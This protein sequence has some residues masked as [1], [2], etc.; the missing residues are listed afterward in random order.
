MS[1]SLVSAR[2]P[3]ALV[4]VSTFVLADCAAGTD[5]IAAG[6]VTLEPRIDRFLREPPEVR[7]D[8]GDLV[9]SG[10]LER[11]LPRDLGGHIDI[12]VIAPDGS[13]VFDAQTDY[14]SETVSSQGRPGPR[15]GYFRRAHTRYGSSGVYLVRFHGL[16]PDSSVVKVSHHLLPHSEGASVRIELLGFPDCPNTPAMRS[17][18]R[19]ALSSL[20]SW[21]LEEVDLSQLA[22]G[23]AQRGWPAPTVLVNGIDLF[24]M[25]APTAGSMGCRVYEGRGGGV[26]SPEQIA[27]ELQR[28]IDSPGQ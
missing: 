2:C 25:P 4:L 23:D 1:N 11:G 6:R 14:R 26:P 15:S 21:S 17:N 22:E 9:V 8:N 20:G 13:T 3:V 19:A 16:P 27:T 5:L 18:L 7:A 10:R 24:G 12:A 28:F